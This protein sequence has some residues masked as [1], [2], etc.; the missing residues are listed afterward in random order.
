MTSSDQRAHPRVPLMLQ[1]QY[2]E[3]EGYLVDATENLSAG[4]AFVRTERPLQT[5]DVVPLVLSFPGLL[6]PLELSS[7]VAWIRPAGPGSPAGVGLMIPEGHVEE[8]KRLAE[9]L[10]RIH[11]ESLS[12]QRR[13]Y[14]ILLVEDN[15]HIMEMYEYVMRK[16]SQSGQVAIEVGVAKDGYD[17]LEKLR[18]DQYDLV[19]TDLF[20]PVLDGFELLRRMRLEKSCAK[21]PVVVI[22]AGGSDTAAQ[23]HAA[24]ADVFLRKPVRFVDVVET[25]SALLKL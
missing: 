21:V 2:P 23:A 12:P 10:A 13:R 16:L 1:V 5:G 7:V 9:I 22:S 6:A 24:G 4:G 18:A 15:P 25:V 8:R 11:N 14:R 17:A 3:Q 20:M 19:V